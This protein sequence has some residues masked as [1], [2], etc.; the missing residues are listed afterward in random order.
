MWNS[1]Q[2]PVINDNGKDYCEKNVCIIESLSCT[3]E[4]KQ[5]CKSTR[6]QEKKYLCASCQVRVGTIFMK[7]LLTIIVRRVCVCVCV[8][9]YRVVCLQIYFFR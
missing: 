3:A 9:A 4:I 7:L 1:V 2:Y 8:H 5:L 6:L